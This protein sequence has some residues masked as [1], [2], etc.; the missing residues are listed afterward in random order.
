MTYAIINKYEDPNKMTQPSYT[1][2]RF[3]RAGISN[4]GLLTNVEQVRLILKA[5]RVKQ[6]HYRQV[7]LKS[8][9]VAKD[10]TDVNIDL[11]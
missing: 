8:D 9:L 5:Y 4:S 2:E 7:K 3:T 11:L 6:V 1:V 10:V